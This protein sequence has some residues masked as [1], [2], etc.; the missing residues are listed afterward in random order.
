[1]KINMK[2]LTN[3]IRKT[4]LL[5]VLVFTSYV[6]DATHLYGGE[7][8]WQCL[9]NGK[10]QF[11]LKVYR[12]CMGMPFVPPSQISVYG[13]P[14]LTSIPINPALTVI[15]DLS[16]ANCGFTCNNP[17][18]G[19]VQEYIMKTDPVI[20]SGTP[21]ASGW[22]FAFDD[23]CRNYCINLNSQ[24]AGS[25][26]RSVMYP[27]NGNNTNPCY[28]SSPFFAE[29]PYNFLCIGYPFT[30]NSNA[31]DVDGD[32][33]VY[34]WDYCVDQ[35]NALPPANFYASNL[36]FSSPYTVQSPI[37]GN[38]VLN[39][40]SGVLNFFVDT[41]NAV[42]GNVACCMKITA[43]RCGIKIAEVYRDC[44]FTLVNNCFV[45]PAPA[46]NHPP[47]Y[48][49]PFAGNTSADT[50]VV[51]GDTVRFT[52]SFVDLEQNIGTTPTQNVILN[53]SGTYFGTDFVIDT[54][55]CPSPPC[56]TLNK[57]L[58]ASAPI[59]NSVT[60][61][62]VPNCTLINFNTCTSS[63][64]NTYY[65]VFDAK[66][67]FCPAPAHAYL[68]ASITVTG[69]LIQQS[70]DTLFVS[71]ASAIAYQWYNGGNLIPGATN[72][73]YVVSIPGMYSCQIETA[74]GCTISQRPL[75]VN[76]VGIGE[77]DVPISIVAVPNPA[78]DQLTITINSPQQQSAMLDLIDVTGRTVYSE[79]LYV[80][81]GKNNL[82][83]NVQSFSRGVYTL[84]L[85]SK[86]GELHEKFVLQ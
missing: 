47:I 78:T 51:A 50:L 28:D 59:S 49:L 65:F 27:L 68:T 57:T 24:G 30:Y 72:S 18:S 7:I 41:A 55:G 61:E 75:L 12:D 15:N 77:V 64:E 23:C 38:P 13:N 2:T 73:Y 63:P 31:I 58:P 44:S 9:G 37:P 83:R 85:S 46:I 3:F 53:A 69:P 86:H 17:Q 76:T 71:Y 5:A 52:L 26:I 16:P 82:E 74:S 29:R 84:R 14:N 66:D 43:Y 80:T 60:F 19:S 20:L 33:L 4:C 62:W 6:S 21:P 45:A 79:K 48:N 1:M 25:T 8:T 54:A 81:K 32:S 39:P 40:T 10:F 22:T 67:D 42:I 56:A 34:S 36:L 70:N 11:T 35:P